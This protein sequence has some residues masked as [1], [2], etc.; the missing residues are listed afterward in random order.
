MLDAD[1]TLYRLSRSV[2]AVYAEVLARFGVSVEAS[3]LDRALPHV[4][5]AFEEDYLARAESYR[6]DPGRERRVWHSF[7]LSL[8]G[9]IG[10]KSPSNEMTDALY[11]EFALGSTRILSEGVL[12]FLHAARAVGV[13]VAVATNNDERT[14]SVLR[15]LGVTAY[16]SYVFS[17]GKLSWK[18]PS[19]HFFDEISRRIGF[20]ASELLHVGN[21]LELDLRAAHTAG[22]DAVLYDPEGCAGEL[23]VR[24]FADLA[25]FVEERAPRGP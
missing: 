8:L 9:A 6:T 4:W 22:W 2:G 7:I 14:E 3:S 21:D 18:K 19:H 11:R 25:C 20:S 13:I 10:L 15:E 5:R 24:S 23:H 17:A 12:E 1:G 16:I